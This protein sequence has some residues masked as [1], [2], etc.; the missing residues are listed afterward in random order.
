MYNVF[1]HH[2]KRHSCNAILVF[3]SLKQNV[4]M[5][6]LP[7][8]FPKLPPGFMTLTWSSVFGLC[9]NSM[10]VLG[11]VFGSVPP[12]QPASRTWIQKV[13]VYLGFCRNAQMFLSCRRGSCT[14]CR[15]RRLIGPVS[16]EWPSGFPV[17]SFALITAPWVLSFTVSESL[18]YYF[19]VCS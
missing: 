2:V 18:I 15:R 5:M 7:G 13:F 11:P 6:T 3:Y 4:P 1:I 19:Y 8:L 14:S 9:V 10:S 12:P 16:W 17:K